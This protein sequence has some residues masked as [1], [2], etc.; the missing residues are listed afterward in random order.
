MV[1]ERDLF[2]PKPEISLLSEKIFKCVSVVRPEKKY[3][4]K[5]GV[6]LTLLPISLLTNTCVSSP[7]P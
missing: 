7:H 6:D 2:L 1:S 5:D 3:P 4:L